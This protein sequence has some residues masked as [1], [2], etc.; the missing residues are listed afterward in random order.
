QERQLKSEVLSLADGKYN[1]WIDKVNPDWSGAIPATIIYK[2]DKR[3]FI[4]ESFASYEEL[5]ASLKQIL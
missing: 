4:G 2:G 3:L 5:D 1:N